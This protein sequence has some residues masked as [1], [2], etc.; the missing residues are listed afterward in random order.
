MELSP[1][2][3][4]PINSTSLQLA[5]YTEL[6]AKQNWFT[7]YRH[8]PH[9]SKHYR[10]NFHYAIFP[11]ISDWFSNFY[12]YFKWLSL[13]LFLKFWQWIM[14]NDL[15]PTCLFKTALTINCKSTLPGLTF[16][17]CVVTVTYVT[18]AVY[19]LRLQ[20]VTRRNQLVDRVRS[21]NMCV[22]S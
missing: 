8:R 2:Q 18:T 22:A 15:L 17:T 20:P 10:L 13:I 6:K 1:S 4:F 5:S 16:T 7:V 9:H 12:N 14:K 3:T 11:S 19:T 21:C